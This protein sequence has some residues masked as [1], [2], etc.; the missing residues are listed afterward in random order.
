MPEERT[1]AWYSTFSTLMDYYPRQVRLISLH[2]WITWGLR[3]LNSLSTRVT[4]TTTK[5][6]LPTRDN[7]LLPP[8][9]VPSPNALQVPYRRLT[10]IQLPKRQAFSPIETRQSTL[11]PSSVQYGP[12]R[13]R[14]PPRT[15]FRS[16]RESVHKPF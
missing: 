16:L 8:L 15:P 14:T 4:S 6:L 5:S 9:G 2:Q 3:R 1:I 11:Q 10:N 7:S 13:S 12:E